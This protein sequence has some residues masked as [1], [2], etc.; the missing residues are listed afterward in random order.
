MVARRKPSLRLTITVALG[1]MTLATSGLLTW[2]SYHSARATLLESARALLGETARRV[3]ERAEGHL[4]AVDDA[5]LAVELMAESGAVDVAD[6]VALESVF[7]ALVREHSELALLEYGGEDGSFLLVQRMPDRSIATRASRRGQAGGSSWRLRAP[8]ATRP[9]EVE[10]TRQAAPDGYDPRRRQWYR[11]G[12]SGLGL[13][14]TEP[15]VLAASREPAVTAAISIDARGARRGVVGGALTLADLA[16]FLATIQLPGQGEVFIVDAQRR[17]LAWPHL[18]RALLGTGD[19]LRLPNLAESG[20]PELRGIAEAPD[21]AAALGGDGGISMLRFTAAGEPQYAALLPLS[22]QGGRRW[23]VGAALPERA[24]LGPIEDGVRRALLL[25]LAVVAVAFLVALAIGR[26]IARPL[27][28]LAEETR[29]I[30]RLDFQA[31]PARPSPFQ[32]ISEI[33]QAYANMKVGLRA[34]EKY[35]PVKLVRQLL[36]SGHEARLGGRVEELTILFSDIRGFSTFAERMQPEELA[37]RLGSY[38]GLMA[39]TIGAS[40]GTVDKYVGDAVMAFWNAPRPV[41]DHAFVGVRAAL[42]CLDAIR[43]IDDEGLFYTRIGVH[44]APVMVGNFGSADRL[45]YTLFGD[46]VNLASRLEG[47][48][49]AYGTQLLLSEDTFRLVAGRIVCRKLDRITVKGKARP[50]EIYEAIGEPAS[51]DAERLRCARLYEEALEAYFGRRFETSL[52][53]FEELAEGAASDVA[54]AELARR[55]RAFLA[56]PPPAGWNGVYEMKTK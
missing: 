16:R 29:L 46:G 34:L 44:T 51:V 37:E 32:E 3:A 42:A 13:Q 25:G 56:D 38:L 12:A 53:G 11:A 6:L 18:E 22:S 40:A 4:A 2:L 21:F 43:G 14:W 5:V 41:A 50:T 27:H 54:A 39:D 23:L 35:V 31:S 8:G 48:N 52:R 17:L 19:D 7:F 28:A 55:C 45:S 30:R 1:L 24:I 33:Q 26:A 36:E 9:A 10:E 47:V 15:Y 20:D 49:K